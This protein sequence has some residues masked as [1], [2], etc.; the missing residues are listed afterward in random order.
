MAFAF[1]RADFAEALIAQAR[2]GRT[3][4]GV[5]EARQLQAGGDSAWQALSRAGLD[6]RQDGN[7]YNLHSK[8]FI[9]D[10][11]IV[12]LGSYNF[13]ASADTQNDE[14]VLIIHNADLAR[15]YWAEWQKVW[16]TAPR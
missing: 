4:Q 14:N 5:F 3:V 7:R 9:I 11:E 12:V 13:T 6:V 10:R 2:A 1:T 16:M 8:V 15:A